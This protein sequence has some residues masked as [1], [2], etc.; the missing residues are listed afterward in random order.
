M[1]LP[2][3]LQGFLTARQQAAQED[4]ATLQQAGQQLGLLAALQKQQKQQKYEQA[5]AGLSPT[6]TPE[7]RIAVAARFAS[8]DKLMEY[9]QQALTR[10][11]ATAA[12]REA[13]QAMIDSRREALDAK[14]ESDKQMIDLRYEMLKN[15][16]ANDEQRRQLE[17]QRLSDQATAAARHD[18]TLRLLGQMSA[19]ARR[20]AAANRPMT[21]FQGKSALYGTRAAQSDKIL[22]ELEDKISLAGL[23]AK[24]SAGRTPVIGGVLGAAGNMM[25][26]PEQQRVEQAQRD[27]VNAVL[28]QE[29]G[30]VISPSEFENAQKQY[31]PVVGDKDEVKAQKRANRKLAIQGF[32]RMSGSG[33][34]DI[35]AIQNAP[36]LPTGGGAAPA[37]V[38][39]A[40]WNAMTPQEKALWQKKP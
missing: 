3:G 12:R 15:S 36:L 27:F 9:Q 8:P 31:F 38:D 24:Q 6:A 4:A 19:D 28:R 20:D 25:L 17:K 29:S 21:E 22:S 39:P 5:L 7:E 40:L 1:A 37:G 16:A 30:A 32:K 13:T 26:S 18:E 34:T 2:V 11:D 35:E 10:Q 33:A 23:S 14:R